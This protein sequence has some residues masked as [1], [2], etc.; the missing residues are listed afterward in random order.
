MTQHPEMVAVAIAKAARTL[1]IVTTQWSCLKLCVHQEGARRP[2]WVVAVSFTPMEL[3]GP[4]WLRA[5]E[6]VAEMAAIV[7]ELAVLGIVD[8]AEVEPTLI[9]MTRAQAAPKE[10]P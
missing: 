6:E 8:G 9:D 4:R 7:R 3:R 10:T 5:Q 2:L 1:P